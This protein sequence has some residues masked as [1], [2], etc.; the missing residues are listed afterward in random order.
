L[1]V[2]G[3]AE[4]KFLWEKQM[5]RALCAGYINRQYLIFSTQLE[6]SGGEP[7]FPNKKMKVRTVVG[8]EFRMSG[9]EQHP[10]LPTV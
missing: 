4:P 10:I 6:F 1:H 3:A 2:Q 7:E 5:F 9:S 8:L